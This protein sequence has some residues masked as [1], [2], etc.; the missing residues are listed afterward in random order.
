MSIF[1]RIARF[2][3]NS[4]N[5]A[6]VAAQAA[7]MEAIN[8]SSADFAASVLGTVDP[9][10]IRARREAQRTIMDPDVADRILDTAARAP[11][12]QAGTSEDPHARESNSEMFR[13]TV[14][15]ECTRLGVDERDFYRVHPALFS[16]YWPTTVAERGPDPDVLD[17]AQEA[18]AERARAAERL[19]AERKA[20]ARAQEGPQPFSLDPAVADIE[21]AHILAQMDALD[22]DEPYVTDRAPEPGSWIARN[23]PA[24]PEHELVDGAEQEGLAAGSAAAAAEMS[25]DGSTAESIRARLANL[26]AGPVTEADLDRIGVTFDQ[27]DRLPQEQ[28]PASVREFVA[29]ENARA[30]EEYTRAYYAEQRAAADALSLGQARAIVA[31]AAELRDHM[32]DCNRPV[33][34]CDTCSDQERDDAAYF[35]DDVTAARTRLSGLSDEQ[36][37]ALE[38]DESA[39]GDTIGGTEVPRAQLAPIENDS[40]AVDAL[41]GRI[42]DVLAE[43]EPTP[44]AEAVEECGQAVDEAADASHRIEVAGEDAERARRLA[45][46]SAE[47]ETH[48]ST[49]GWE[50]A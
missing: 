19:Q 12:R 41:L 2:G 14:S 31:R 34:H 25:A 45:R 10:D 46:W 42:D 18:A 29:A 1:D 48:E 20:A 21:L 26:P 47:D 35:W 23:L 8:A 39:D 33:E 17:H 38:A 22:D 5:A 7:Q 27:V 24:R 43:P 49:E 37:A 16:R 44:L 3:K 50:R 15:S 30:D 28:L 11:W 36:I 4:R 32:N 6:S 40:E 13:R 9:Q